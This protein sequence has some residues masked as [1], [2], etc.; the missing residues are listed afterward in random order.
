MKPDDILDAIGA[1]DDVYVKK[2]KERKKS[3]AAVWITVSTIAACLVLF[4]LLPNIPNLIGYSAADPGHEGAN[5]ATPG[6]V[7]QPDNVITEIVIIGNESR[8]SYASGEQIEPIVDFIGNVFATKPGVNGEFN[9]DAELQPDEFLIV[10]KDQNGIETEYRL[11]QTCFY[12][13][14]NGRKYEFTI[15]ELNEFKNLL[16]VSG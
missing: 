3:G 9:F 12:D 16:G 6:G 8:W 5:P 13:L 14:S 2:A 4:F 7:Y 10:L 11:A 15:D 1:V